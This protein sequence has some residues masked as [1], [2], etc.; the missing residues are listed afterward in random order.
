MNGKTEDLYH[1]DGDEKK[2]QIVEEDLVESEPNTFGR[3]LATGGHSSHPKKE[4][5]SLKI[6]G[7]YSL[8][9]KA[10]IEF[11]YVQFFIQEADL[12]FYQYI[13]DFLIPK[14]CNSLHLNK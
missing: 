8:K 7:K 12:V 1:N 10:L 14:V 9:F 4:K 6:G 13:V 5:S 11:D 3:H 2:L